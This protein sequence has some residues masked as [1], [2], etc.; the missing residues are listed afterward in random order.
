M[1]NYLHIIRI[2]LTNS[3]S[4]NAVTLNALL[5]I[6]HIS[7]PTFSNMIFR[8]EV[9]YWGMLSCYGEVL[10]KFYF[11][12]IQRLILVNFWFWQTCGKVFLNTNKDDFLAKFW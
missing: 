4:S 12:L 10:A 5:I 9:F 6:T 3:I 7:L 2:N 8:Q 11:L 1:I